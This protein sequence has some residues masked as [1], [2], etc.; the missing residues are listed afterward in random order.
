[1]RI[2]LLI[3]ALLG[4][5]SFATEAAIDHT[6]GTKQLEQL[7][8]K[9]EAIRQQLAKNEG[10]KGGLI[11]QLKN[12]E[13]K[14]GKI[15]RSLR[16]TRKQLNQQKKTLKT[17]QRKR[18]T[19]VSALRKQRHALS[20][21]I[22]ASY[23]MGHSEQIKLILNQHDPSRINRILTYHQYLSRA[24]T[25]LIKDVLNKLDE[26][27]NTETKIANET[28][29]LNKLIKRQTQKK[30]TLV[31]SRKKRNTILT[32]LQKKIKHEGQQLSTLSHDAKVL[33]ELL[34]SIDDLL[35]DIPDKEL[36]R[37]FAERRG[38]HPWPIKGLVRRLFGQKKGASELRWNG[39]IIS[40]QHGADVRAAANGRIAFA[41]WLRGLGMLIIIDHGDGYMTLHGHNQALYGETGDWVAKGDV[42]AT[43]GDSGGQQQPGLYFEIRHNGKPLNPLKWFSKRSR[44]ASR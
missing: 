23:Q 17:L 2:L 42:I 32:G 29:F 44:F 28:T 4:L 1:M 30:K 43:V 38:K 20:Q 26:I 9:I 11:N 16:S 8:D 12:T 3:F 10:K 15:N 39:I 40:A 19:Q 27:N 34:Q 37:P 25:T 21:Q 24:R 35:S 18:R 13:K 33:E 36:T 6:A 22:R 14:L 5:T 41:D 7:R 31:K